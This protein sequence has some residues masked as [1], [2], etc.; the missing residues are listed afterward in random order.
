MLYLFT[1]RFQYGIKNGKQ[2]TCGLNVIVLCLP[3]VSWLCNPCWCYI[4]PF[5]P[6]C[7][8]GSAEVS[9]RATRITEDHSLISWWD[10]KPENDSQFIHSCKW[11]G[12]RRGQR[13]EPCGSR[14]PE[15][16]W[17]KHWT[18]TCIVYAVLLYSIVFILTP[19]ASSVFSWLILYR[20]T[21]PRKVLAPTVV[22]FS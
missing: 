13:F 7:N 9:V 22:E 17:P 12:S 20:G 11:F 18:S 14:S 15:D 2:K 8:T 3:M 4:N 6:S 10:Q 1:F 21:E 16:A 5:S 19:S